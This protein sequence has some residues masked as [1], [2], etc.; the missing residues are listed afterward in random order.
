MLPPN[1]PKMFVAYPGGCHEP[2]FIADA[3][4][5]ASKLRTFLK[6]IP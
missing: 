6:S 4:D 3:V 2:L 5:Y 1:E